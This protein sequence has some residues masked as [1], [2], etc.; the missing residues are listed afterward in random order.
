MPSSPPSPP[1]PPAGFPWVLTAATAAALAVLLLLGGWQMQRLAWKEALIARAEAAGALPPAPLAEVLAEPD[2]EFRRAIVLC[3]G[4]DRAPWVEL[5]SIQDGEPG[6]RLVSVCRPAGLDRAILVDRGF[7]AATISMR[8]PR[9]ASTMPV[10]VRLV[11]R[12]TP[13]PGAMTPEPQD[14]LFYG[15]DNAA[16]ARALGVE[17]PVDPRTF[18]AETSTN[19]EW[20]AL[21]PAAPPAAFSNNHLGYA[22]TWFGLAV[23]LVGVYLALLRRRM[24]R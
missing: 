3:P 23:A 2:P 20:R 7:V 8:P 6:V 18:Y 24:K 21:R 16:M 17:G 13:P 10:S 9:E 11:V 12:E 15:R 1:Q 4:L 14:W 22:V 19:P 5:N